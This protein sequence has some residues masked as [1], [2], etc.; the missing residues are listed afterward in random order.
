MFKFELKSIH[1][2]DRERIKGNYEKYFKYYHNK[3]EVAKRLQP[4]IIL[5][6]GVRAGYSALAFMQACQDALLVGYDSN[7][8]KHSGAKGLKYHNWAWD[9]LK[10][11]NVR[12][13]PDFDTQTVES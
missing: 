4:G 1:E 11:Y 9:I 6:I 5:E 8:G 12:L 10:R 3:Y 7:D 13:N 2:D